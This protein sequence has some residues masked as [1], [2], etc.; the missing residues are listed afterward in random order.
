MTLFKLR[1]PSEAVVAE[2]VWILIS[3]TAALMTAASLW[4]LAQ[5]AEAGVTFPFGLAITGI[6]LVEILARLRRRLKR[7]LSSLRGST[8]RQSFDSHPGAKATNEA[9]KDS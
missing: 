4:S 2:A 3:R 5:G 6:G 8:A 9:G 1:R 7:A